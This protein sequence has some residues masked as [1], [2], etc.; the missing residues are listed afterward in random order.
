MKKRILLLLLCALAPAALFA[1]E[2]GI[3][4]T[5]LN[6]NNFA[7]ETKG[8][9]VFID[10]YA[11]WC[12]PCKQFAP[13]FEAVAAANPSLN[14]VKVDTDACPKLSAAFKINSIPYIVA[15][16]DNKV[17]AKFTTYPRSEKTF[18]TWVKKVVQAVENQE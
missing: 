11:D 17:I 10:F 16:K 6:D 13:V 15:Y 1:A 18:D 3:P 14:F 4:Y 12:G 8:K 2:G 7:S 5:V 9:L